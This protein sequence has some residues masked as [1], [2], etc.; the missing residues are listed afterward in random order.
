MDCI[1]DTF[2]S[3]I[4]HILQNYTFT[5]SI[6]FKKYSFFSFPSLSDTFLPDVRQQQQHS[7]WLS[8]PRKQRGIFLPKLFLSKLKS[9][10]SWTAEELSFYIVDFRLC[11]RLSWVIGNRF[12]RAY[13][14]FLSLPGIRDLSKCPGRSYV[15]Y[16]SSGA[17]PE[18]GIIIIIRKTRLYTRIP[19]VSLVPLV[20][21]LARNRRLDRF[22]GTHG[23]YDRE[24]R[25][26][27]GQTEIRK[28][29]MYEK[30][31]FCLGHFVS[32][33]TLRA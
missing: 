32:L 22:F 33:A 25:W 21:H 23:S 3:L 15:N 6:N 7:T 17:S 13:G 31:L 10:C 24:Q 20:S 14:C 8:V 28:Q 18:S 4:P 30:L 19:P 9:S 27:A 1:S 16:G 12:I 29:G 2:S 26:V 5:K 11:R